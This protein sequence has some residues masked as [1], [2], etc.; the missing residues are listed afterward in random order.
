[1]IAVVVS[2]DTEADHLGHLWQKTAPL[3]F[4]SI[5]RGIPER[6]SPLFQAYGARPTYLVT[7]EVLDDA[8]SV[9]QL[10]RLAD[11]ELGAHLH[12]DHVA[13][14]A[15]PA[16]GAKSWDFT[17]FYSAELE[18]AKLETL[19]R[20]FVDRIGRRP[21]SYRAGRYAASGKTAKALVDLG[22]RV[23]T[24]V[25]PGIEWIHE[26]HP[27]QHLDFRPAPRSPYRPAEND[28]ASPGSLP[29]W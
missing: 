23:E 5:T 18:R 13:P 28:L 16:A 6:L 12:G 27:S 7:T 19:T 20:Q 3:R 4:Q 24:S 2:I 17:C 15:T 22:Y 29:I 1:M 26:H 11:C 21:V 25:T 10:T 14:Q 9:E 8:A